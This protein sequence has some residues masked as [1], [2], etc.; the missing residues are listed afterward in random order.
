MDSIKNL[1]GIQSSGH[2]KIHLHDKDLGEFTGLSNDG[3]RIT[4]KGT[5]DFAGTVI[6][7]F[8]H[9]SAS[10][11][12]TTEKKLVATALQDPAIFEKEIAR[13]LAEHFNSK[14]SFLHGYAERF[15]LLS[16]NSNRDSIH[17]ILED[18][19]NFQQFDIAFRGQKAV[20]VYVDE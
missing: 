11:L 19:D 5:R 2:E 17:F 6:S 4:W 20:A 15:R 16:I 1:F 10:Q 18:K 7:L 9:G 3:N 14:D 12:D 8:I 13:S